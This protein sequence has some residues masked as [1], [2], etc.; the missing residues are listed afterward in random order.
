MSEEGCLVVLKSKLFTSASIFWKS[1]SLHLDGERHIWFSSGLYE[2]FHTGFS[3]TVVEIRW[4]FYGFQWLQFISKMDLVLPILRSGETLAFQEWHL[5]YSRC[6]SMLHD[7]LTW[8]STDVQPHRGER[9]WVRAAERAHT[10]SAQNIAQTLS[11]RCHQK[12]PILNCQKCRV[13]LEVKDDAGNELHLER[14]AHHG[15]TVS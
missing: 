15:C 3:L 9:R 12:S 13:P 5:V 6:E 8:K 7:M 10:N 1:F 4:Y 14:W 2:M 11:K